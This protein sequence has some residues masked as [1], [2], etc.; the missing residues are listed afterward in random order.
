MK[1]YNYPTNY[2]T[3]FFIAA[4]LLGL[5]SLGFWKIKEI[6][7]SNIKINGLVKFIK[8]IIQEIRT[9]KKLRNYI[10]LTNTQ[11]I[12]MGLMPFLILYAKSN[13]GAGSQDVGN[14]LLLKVVGGFLTSIIIYYYS[15]KVKY[16]YMLYVISIIAI[17]IPL[18]ILLVPGSVLFPYIFLAGG[19]V[20]TIYGI[21]IG[22][23]LLEITT[24]ENRA[25][26]TGLSG[27]ASIF[28]GIFALLGG[29]IVTKFGFTHFF[30][31][32]IILLSLSFYFIYKLDCQK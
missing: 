22:G 8:V 29:W 4:A 6:P 17:L 19:I 16:Q 27:A 10:F 13:F 30:I 2:A 12:S 31:L 3:L 20:F 14:F 9:N 5:A 15:K 1:E 18:L 11:G 32:F 7:A 26:H 25:L 21:S 23:I 28:P 24:N